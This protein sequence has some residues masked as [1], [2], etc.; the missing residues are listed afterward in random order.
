VQLT[1]RIWK[2]YRDLAICNT[3]TRFLVSLSSSC[4]VLYS[5]VRGR[6][7]LQKLSDLLNLVSVRVGPT[8]RLQ[9][10]IEILSRYTAGSLQVDSGLTTLVEGLET[11]LPDWLRVANPDFIDDG[12]QAFSTHKPRNLCDLC[13]GISFKSFHGFSESESEQTLP[14]SVKEDFLFFKH[15]R[16]LDALKISARNGCWFCAHIA[17]ASDNYDYSRDAHPTTLS[18]I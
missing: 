18:G 17:F 1:N 14:W 4:N 8:R 11:E 7:L 10:A 15:Q 5:S 3:S 9:T 12:A 2:G 6:E 16:S 13:E